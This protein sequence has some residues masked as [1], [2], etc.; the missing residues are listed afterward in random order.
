MTRRGS[1]PLALEFFA[2]IGLARIGLESAGFRIA[3]SNDYEPSKKTLYDAQFPDSDQHTFVLGDVAGVRGADLPR[4]TSLAWASSP[5]TDLSLAGGRAGLA[6]SSSGAFWHFT[7]LLHEL[8]DDRPGL[9]V[10]ENVV[11]LASSHR[12]K[13]M[14]SAIRAF[15]DLGYSV[16]ALMIDARRFVPQSR[17]RLFLVGVQDPPPGDQEQHPLRPGRLDRFFEDPQLTTHRFAL[18]QPPPAMTE[19][20]SEII[21]QIPPQRWWGT[22]QT[23][24]FLAMM[25]EPQL[26]RVRSLERAPDTQH[27]TAY[28]RTRAGKLT[29]EVRDDAIAGCLRTAGGGSS[30]QALVEAGKG[31]LRVRWLTPQEYARL[32]G[33]G[34]YPLDGVR[35]DPAL[36]GF[37]DAVAVPVVAW[38]AENYLAPLAGL[39]AC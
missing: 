10:L 23:D 26:E 9:V 17:P 29:W 25:A 19:G 8:G 21:E 39:Y 18:P 16:D 6:G 5:C 37:G 22:A 7:R 35:H 38:L 30:R 2:G 12:G 36:S 13:D 14:A 20:L 32:M 15:N 11:G 4:G 27:R 31:S 3:W 34:Q 33:A 28:R 24:S 1:N